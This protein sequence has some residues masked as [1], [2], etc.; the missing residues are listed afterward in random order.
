MEN[1]RWIL[2]A[3][4]IFFILAIYFFGRQRR[5]NNSTDVSDLKED[6][7]E[8]SAR[9]WDDMEE[10][11]GRVRIVAREHHEDDFAEQQA[12]ADADYSIADE[13]YSRLDSVDE[14]DLTGRA[15]LFEPVAEAEPLAVEPPVVDG[16]QAEPAPQKS[17]NV[18]IIVL[19][20]LAK[21]STL[22][23]GEKINSVAQAN[24]FQFGRMN[25]YHRLDDNGQTIFS[26][27]N[28][29]EP[30]NF[31]PDTIHHMTTSGLTV[32]TQLSN[33]SHPADDFDEM[34]RSAY[35]MSE[36]LGASLCN[37]KR[38][39]ITQ[40]DVEYYRKLIAEKENA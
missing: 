13:P 38:Q 14:T 10:G 27:A 22:L 29:L 4:G 36:M 8:F 37:Q 21:P 16:R 35:Y 19:Y 1:L 9:D 26:L 34:L 33:L 12:Q 6:L 32:F 31:D 40:A 5:R 3:A 28:M 2:L 15:D 39:P 7:P 11:V 23:T 20:I 25:I 30:G 24:G 17:S 18:D